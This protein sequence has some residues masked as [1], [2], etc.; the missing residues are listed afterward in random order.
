MIQTIGFSQFCDGFSGSHKDNFTYEG[1]RA[2]FDYLEQLEEDTGEQIEFDA[3]GLCCDYTQYDS[4]Y[5]AMQQYQPEDMPLEGE[6]GDDLVEIT[7]KEE[8][9]A[10]RWLQERTQVIEVENGGVIIQDF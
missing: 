9:E 2:L 4:A 3:I 6:D 5:E 8:K 7:E 1:K 10:L